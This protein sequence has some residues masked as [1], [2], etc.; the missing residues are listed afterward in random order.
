MPIFFMI[1]LCLALLIGMVWIGR[2]FAIRSAILKRQILTS[3]SYA[4][5]PH[6]APKVSVLVAAKDEEDNIETCIST[7]LDQDYPDYEIIA[8]NDRSKDQTS[9]ILQRLEQQAPGQLRVINIQQLREGWFGK[10]HAMHEGVGI[11]QGEWFMFTDADCRQISKKT[12]SM[13]MREAL[14]HKTDFLSITPVLETKTITEKILQPVC[15]LVLMIW[16]VLDRVND[17]ERKTAYAN[18][19]FML[20]HRS[21]YD[22]IGG[23]ERVRLEIS[24]DILMA[25]NAKKMGFNLRV[26]ENDDLYRTR[27][28]RNFM[29]SWQGW[30]RIFFGSLRTLERLGKAIMMILT[31]TILPWLCLAIAITGRIL[32]D[33][34]NLVYWN[35]MSLAWLTVIVI[36]QAALWRYYGIVRISRIWSLTYVI[37]AA[38]ALTMLINAIFNVLGKSHITWRGTTYRG[39]QVENQQGTVT[40]NQNEH[41]ATNPVD[42]DLKPDSI[43]KIKEP[44]TH[45]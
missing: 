32:T 37:G 26:V 31:F 2:Y 41:A 40:V 15:T 35:W 42:C 16:F 17:P 21:C 18:G 6:P 3:N 38:T 25:Q 27:M 45:G 7:L 36:K 39:N 4:G 8:I 10:S 24:E 34:E 9:A 30:S 13:A 14:A 12:I 44:S 20:M 19:A 43:D 1:W 11:S 28:Y 33:P 5:P 23:H 22:A 29:E